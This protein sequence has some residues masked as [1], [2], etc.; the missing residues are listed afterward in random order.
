ML[1]VDVEDEDAGRAPILH[2][3]F[4]AGHRDVEIAAKLLC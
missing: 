3:V 4:R 1:V 2:V